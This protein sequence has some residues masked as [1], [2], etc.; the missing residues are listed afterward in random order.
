M[1]KPKSLIASEGATSIA[2]I[3]P[4]FLQKVRESALHERLNL[5]RTIGEL[6]ELADEI[7]ATLK[8]LKA[9]RGD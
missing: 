9:Q 5:S 7:D 4:E 6:T 3:T 2:L 1:R 8:F